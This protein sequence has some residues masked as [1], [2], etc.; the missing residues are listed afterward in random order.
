MDP[1]EVALS[2]GVEVGVDIGMPNVCSAE[3]PGIG[4]G[5][6]WRYETV[7]AGVDSCLTWCE[8]D[9]ADA[10]ET[11]RARPACVSRRRLGPSF[12][13]GWV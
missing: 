9:D 2:D 1:C 12:T 13:F 10:D 6:E 8:D 3:L 11:A 7:L 5:V 4:V